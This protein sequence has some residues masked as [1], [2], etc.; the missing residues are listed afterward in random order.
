MPIVKKL[1]SKIPYRWQMELKRLHFRRQINK[2]TFLTSEPEFKILN[3]LIRPGDWVI[4]IG[5]NVGHYT[6]R[7]SE[8]VGPKGRVIA[9]EPVPA[10]FS[11][12]AANVQ[13]FTY[14]NVTLFNI[15]ISDKMEIVGISIPKFSS[16]MT[17]YY[18]A[19]LTSSSDSEFSVL[20]LPLDSLDIRQRIGLVKI[21]A[22]GHESFVLAG[23]RKLIEASHP[24]LIVETE[25]EQLIR[26]LEEMG[27][28]SEKMKNSPNYLFKSLTRERHRT[29]T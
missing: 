22:E 14:A 29:P 19:H 13:L 10:T 18:Q 27:Y 20:T 8:L 9:I 21:D 25:S 24:I 6:K 1:L 28:H 23:M 4:D 5:A 15:A 16:G 11:L 12:L 17:N 3:E 2:N 26:G 7:F